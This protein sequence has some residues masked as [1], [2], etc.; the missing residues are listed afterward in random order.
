MPAAT[1]LREMAAG[2]SGE[3][4]AQRL[5]R[6]DPWTWTQ[7]QA[8]ALRRRDIGTIDWE[9]VIEEIETLGRSE[10]RAWVSHCTN[11]I[12][13]LLKIEY[14][15]SAENLNH[16]RRE[17]RAFRKGMFRALEENPGM[18]GRLA[19]LLARA[20]RYGRADAVEAIA[21]QDA[22]GDAAAERRLARNWRGRLPE[23]CPYSL[24]HV[25]GYDPYRRDGQL[26]GDVWP[27]G[28]ARVLNDGLG[29]DY[30]IRHSTPAREAGRSR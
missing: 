9:N 24:E 23:D 1:S 3:T 26:L 28:V 11:T 22:A 16:W 18:K 8:D 27:A 14:L 10:E 30:P 29:T 21:E 12:A 20:W 13:H 5:Y 19:R 15:R 6:E 17:I 7:E 25:A 2:A 4:R